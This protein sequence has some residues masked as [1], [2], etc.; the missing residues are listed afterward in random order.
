[1]IYFILA[2][3][4]P[5]SVGKLVRKLQDKDTYFVIHVD[6]NY[7]IEPFSV[8][9]SDIENC[10][11]TPDRFATSWGSFSLVE[12]TLHAFKYIK[13]DLRKQGRIVLLSGACYPIKSSGYIRDY[14]ESHPDTIFI[15]Y[16]AVPRKTWS[17][18]GVY[19]FPLY[20][21]IKNQMDL[22]GGS[23]WFSIPNRALEIIF[24]FLELNPDF[25]EYFRHVKIPDESFF[26]TLFL[27]CEDSYAIKNLKNQNLHHIKWEWP[28][29][30]PST[31]TSKD[32][33]DLKRSE[34][35]FAR[36]FNPL[37]SNSLLKE[38]DLMLPAETEKRNDKIAILF[39]TDKPYD[40]IKARYEKLKS[41][42]GEDVYLIMTN[43]DN[44]TEGEKIMLYEHQYYR[45]MGYTPFNE[46]KMVP[47]STYFS[48]LH[49]WR[50][51]LAYQYYWLIEDDV[52]YEGDWNNFFSEFSH[53]HADFISSYF[54]HFHHAPDWYW[55]NDIN[56]KNPVGNEY[57][58]RT[59]YPVCRLSFPALV[60]LDERLKSGDYG[61][62]EVLVPTL[63]SLKG[64]TFYDIANH[65]A[66][67]IVPCSNRAVGVSN[68]GSFRYR[69]FISKKEIKG[70]FLFHPVKENPI[71][72]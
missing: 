6:K 8:A 4:F 72:E 2:H 9:V 64:F 19:R 1:M 54:T 27:N 36:K 47:G 3:N 10:Y 59:F 56:I 5:E 20:H 43:R 21:E 50:S 37:D 70:N 30:H 18:G 23:Q 33:G 65:P 28:F 24:E 55:W 25:L 53:N 39:L 35:L 62:G 46:E 44:L 57:K 31:M 7:D 60:Y 71:S 16:E 41:E 42:S 29:M 63:L 66:P 17:M 15:E 34:S 58:I 38:L 22:Y 45:Q 12:A 67:L 69:P 26:Q 68:N 48:L 32:L 13:D 61:H 51:H 14:L 40:T 49:F 52:L 11:F